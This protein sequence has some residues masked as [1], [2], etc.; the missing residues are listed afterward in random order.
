MDSLR[1]LLIAGS[2][3]LVFILVRALFSGNIHSQYEVTHR[4]E[5]P[6]TF[7]ALWF[8]LLLPLI[9]ILMLVMRLKAH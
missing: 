8:V 3:A 4:D 1:L 2:V 9:P 7:W 5:N 6:G